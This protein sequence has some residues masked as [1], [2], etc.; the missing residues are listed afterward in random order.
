MSTDPAEAMPMSATG[1]HERRF[2]AR[3]VTTPMART[4]IAMVPPRSVNRVTH[5]SAEAVRDET[6]A[7]STG[8]SS[9]ARSSLSTTAS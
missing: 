1:S 5:C 8:W 7:S 6:A 4:G 9:T 3:I 2:T